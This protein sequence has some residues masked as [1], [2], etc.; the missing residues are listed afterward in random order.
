MISIE[1]CR[2]SPLRPARKKTGAGETSMEGTMSPSNPKFASGKMGSFK[3]TWISPGKWPR[4]SE[5]SNRTR[6]LAS[7]PG[8]TDA[9]MLVTMSG[10]VI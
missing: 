3:E 5:V 10:D 8:G 6:I 2:S 1:A 9:G 4:S 7:V